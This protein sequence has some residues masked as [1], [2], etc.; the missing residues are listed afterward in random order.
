[1]DPLTILGVAAG[2]LSV[3]L[4]GAV[5]RRRRRHRQEACAAECRAAD[6]AYYANQYDRPTFWDMDTQLLVQLETIADL[7]TQVAALER[8]LALAQTT[9]PIA[10]V[11]GVAPAYDP[12]KDAFLIP[13]VVVQR[14]TAADVARHLQRA[15]DEPSVEAMNRALATQ[16]AG[17]LNDLFGIRVIRPERHR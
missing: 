17:H 9:R 11:T 7:R 14:Q 2:L 6:A 15:L 4:A 10:D 16:P 5:V 12:L 8:Q 3:D 1:M 13:R